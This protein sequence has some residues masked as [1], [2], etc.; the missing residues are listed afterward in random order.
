[1]SHV[2]PNSPSVVALEKQYAQVHNTS[3]HINRARHVQNTI[4]ML[5]LACIA[6]LA[7][8]LIPIKLL[9]CCPLTVQV[10]KLTIIGS[11]ASLAIG[12]AITK[13]V[14]QQLKQHRSTLLAKIDG[15]AL[16]DAFLADPKGNWAELAP[17]LERT[18]WK[19]WAQV[20][21]QN[22]NKTNRTE[23][24]KSMLRFLQKNCPI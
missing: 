2:N 6:A 5:A 10:V 3:G 17:N 9:N 15:R 13:I 23:D 4:A 12:F 11:A 8:S 16:Y 1:M 18:Q 22:L 19:Q 21:A 24:E 7:L 20:A 14:T